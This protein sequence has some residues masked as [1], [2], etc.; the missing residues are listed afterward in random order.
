MAAAKASASA[1]MPGSWSPCAGAITIPGRQPDICLEAPL[2]EKAAQTAEVASLAG[3]HCLYAAQGSQEIGAR[4]EFQMLC[5]P[6][7]MTCSASSR[8]YQNCLLKTGECLC[9]S[10]TQNKTAKH[11]LI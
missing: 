4:L 3:Q 2:T 1:S 10:T 9:D 7:A 6:S 8:C 11:L 5:T